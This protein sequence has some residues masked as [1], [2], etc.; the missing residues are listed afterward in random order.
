ML[1]CSAFSFLHR[2]RLRN[3][4]ARSLRRVVC[5]SCVSV[6]QG[7]NGLPHQ[8][9]H[10]LAMT[11]LF[12]RCR[13]IYSW[14]IVRVPRGCGLPHQCAHWF[15]MTQFFYAAVSFIHCAYRG[16]GGETDCHTSDVGH[17]FAK[18]R[19]FLRCRVIYTF[20]GHFT[21]YFFTIHYY[22]SLCAAAPA[23]ALGSS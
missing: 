12:L 4:R 7:E 2:G 1:A 10:W 16:A 8:C 15:A 11:P 13:V 21:F 19:L 20:P 14:Y 9:A 6:C 17:W 18:T 23:C 22:L 5:S 3:G